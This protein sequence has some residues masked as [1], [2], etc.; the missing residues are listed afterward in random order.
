MILSTNERSSIVPEPTHGVAMPSPVK[1]LE[2]KALRLATKDRAE[3]ARIL[4]LS[5][6]DSDDQDAE[7]VWAEEAE[8]RYRE[9][10]AGTVQAVASERVFEEARALL[11]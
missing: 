6:E 11:K 7:R 1:T 2:A 10:K 4:L 8:R 3:L 5:L 9:I